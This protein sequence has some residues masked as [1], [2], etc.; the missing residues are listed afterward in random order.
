MNSFEI[1]K[2]ANL[3]SAM[4]L[5]ARPHHAALAGGVDLLDLLKQRIEEPRALVDLNEIAELQGIERTADGGLRL[6][7]LARLGDVA[8]HPW[9]RELFAAIAE[10]IW[11]PSAAIC[12]N[13]RDAGIFAI[14]RSCAS[15]RAATPAMR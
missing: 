11:P 1:L 3:D 14:P 8:A 13:V 4:R 2:P 15:R 5:L 12:C 10:A 9:V 6:G 7:A